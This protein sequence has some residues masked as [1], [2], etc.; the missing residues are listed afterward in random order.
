MMVSYCV[1]F[2][3]LHLSLSISRNPFWDASQRST[4]ILSNPV[5][6]LFLGVVLETLFLTLS[7]TFLM[8]KITYKFSESLLR[9]SVS[10]GLRRGLKKLVSNNNPG[11]FIILQVRNTLMTYL[12]LIKGH[13]G[14]LNCWHYKQCCSA[15]SCIFFLVHMCFSEVQAEE[16]ELMGYVVWIFY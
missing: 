6:H 12:F 2:Y 7:E 14:S 11:G 10:T 5:Y 1:S 15:H 16:I 3:S 13:L 9:W 8:I 4:L